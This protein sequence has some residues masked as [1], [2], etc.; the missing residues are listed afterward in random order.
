M[1]KIIV[2]NNAW[3][4]LT[5]IQIEAE[6]TLLKQLE[7]Q[8]IEIPNACRIGICASCLCTAEQGSE[9]LIKNLTGE[10]AFP[11]AEEEIMTCIGWVA[12]TE[13]EII[14]TTMS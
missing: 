2:K 3:E 7:A 10:P 9:H 4:I 8:G 14:L 5:S 1:T 11:L 13:E 12:D 6:K